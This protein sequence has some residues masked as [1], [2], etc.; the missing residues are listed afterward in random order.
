MEIVKRDMFM[1]T[2]DVFIEMFRRAENT[3]VDTMR[4]FMRPTGGLGLAKENMTRFVDEVI[5]QR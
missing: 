3:G 1:G 5:S 2:T 4:I